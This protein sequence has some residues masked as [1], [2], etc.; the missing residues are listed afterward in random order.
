MLGHL[1]FT[2]LRTMTTPPLGPGTEPLIEQQVALDVGLDD[3]EVERRDL[4]VAHV[5][6]HLQ[7]LEH[8]A[9]EAARADRA[10]AHGGA[11]GCRGWRPDH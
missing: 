8:A 3:L 4:L 6:G 7:A 10:R 5:T 9:G 1:P 2:A 11:C